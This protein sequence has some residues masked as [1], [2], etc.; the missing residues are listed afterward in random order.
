MYRKQIHTQPRQTGNRLYTP[1]DSK[2][3]GAPINVHPFWVCPRDLL[4]H[5]MYLASQMS[6]VDNTPLQANALANAGIAVIASQFE[7]GGINGALLWVGFN[8]ALWMAWLGIPQFRE[9]LTAP[10]LRDGLLLP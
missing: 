2:E 8:Y 5:N 1:Q 9:A 4:F 3:K 10:E 6:L 7:L